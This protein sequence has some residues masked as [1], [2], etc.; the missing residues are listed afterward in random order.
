MEMI[1]I[2]IPLYNKEDTIERAI[3]SVLAQIVSDWELIVID[4]GSTDNGPNL[5]KKFDDPR[6][7]L[8]TQ[9]NAGVSAARNHGVQLAKADVIAFLDGD[10]YWASGHLASLA[11]LIGRFPQACIFATAYFNVSEGGQLCKTRLKD[12]DG[13]SENIRILNYFSDACDVAPP[14]CSS[15]VAVSKNALTK[16]GG[17]PKGVKAGEDLITWARLACLGDVAYATSA[18][19]YY[20]LPPVS[21]I[22]HQKIRRP[23][24]PDYVGNELAELSRQHMHLRDSLQLYQ[25]NWHRIRAMSFMELNDRKDSLMELRKAIDKSGVRMRDIASIALLFLPFVWRAR[26]LARWRRRQNAVALATH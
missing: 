25:G 1:S 15:A 5:V 10:D 9:T 8:T 14:V 18:S 20:V 17:F 6:I 3:N 23:P 21:A 11:H 12:E 19:A 16:I 26:L 7:R 4:D 24:K 2:V 13:R 22:R